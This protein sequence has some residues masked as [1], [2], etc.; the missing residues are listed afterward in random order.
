MFTADEVNP[1]VN[2]CVGALQVVEAAVVVKDPPEVQLV[3]VLHK[4]ILP[5]NNK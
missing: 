3:V 2:N 5:R 4:L 1:S